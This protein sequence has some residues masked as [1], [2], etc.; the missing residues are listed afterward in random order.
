MRRRDGDHD[1]RLADADRP[2]AMVDCHVR[3]VV[4]RAQVLGD[5]PHGLLGHSFVRLVLEPG[6]HAATRGLAGRPQERRNRP[7]AVVPYLVD[8]L[9]QRERRLGEQEGAARDRRDQRHLVA[10]LERTI[11]LCVFLVD[12]IEQTGRLVAEPEQGPHGCDGGRF[13]LALRPTGALAQACE[14]TDPNVRHASRI[15]ARLRR[16][17]GAIGAA[18]VLLE[19]PSGPDPATPTRARART[20]RA[21]CERGGDR[22]PRDRVGHRGEARLHER[23]RADAARGSR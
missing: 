1:R 7:R 22:S 19:S 10:V 21:Y 15:V 9:L 16:H 18:Q 20:G 23:R 6:D 4:A 5:P 12:R 3:H 2:D 13:E 17:V 11:T 14:Q 8:G